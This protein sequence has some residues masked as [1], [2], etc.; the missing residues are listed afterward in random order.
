MLQCNITYVRY[1]SLLSE[2][3]SYIRFCCRTNFMP[4]LQPIRTKD[5]TLSHVVDARKSSTIHNFLSDLKMLT[6][7]SIFL[8]I[9]SERTLTTQVPLK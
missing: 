6:I 1:V 8:F 4:S 7:M 9:L 5:A 3:M 2:N